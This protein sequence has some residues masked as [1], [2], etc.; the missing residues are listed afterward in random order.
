MGDVLRW[1][2]EARCRNGV[3]AGLAAGLL[4]AAGGAA[5][6]ADGVWTGDSGDW[7][8]PLIWV[9]GTVAGGVD[10]SASFPADLTADRTIFVDG[11]V[12]AGSLAFSDPDVFL[13]ATLT[14]APTTSG[15]LTLATT[16]DLPTVD[17]VDQSLIISSVLAGGQGLAK[18]GSGRLVLGNDAN[19]FSGTL[20]LREGSLQLAGDGSLGQVFEITVEN[21]AEI[22]SDSEQAVSIGASRYM[23]LAADL[24]FRGEDNADRQFSVAAPIVGTGGLALAGPTTDLTLAGP[25]SFEGGISV[26][27]GGSSGGSSND[28]TLVVGTGPTDLLATLGNGSNPV[29]LGGS[30]GGGIG[31][32]VLH[33]QRDDY[34]YS[35][36]ISGSGRVRVASG[37]RDYANGSTLEL[38]GTNTYTGITELQDTGLIVRDPANLS[39][40]TVVFNRAGM[41][42][43][44]GDLDPAS[45]DDFTRPVGTGFEDVR[46]GGGGGFGAMGGT[47]T[48]NLHGDGRQ[49]VWDQALYNWATLFLSHPDA[50]GTVELVNGLGLTGNNNSRRTITTSDGLA[51]IDAIISGV[52][53]EA[54]TAPGKVGLNLQGDGTLQLTGANTYGGGTEILGST[55]VVSNVQSGGPSNIGVGYFTVKQGGT[56][57]YTGTGAE[58]FDRGLWTDNGQ[59][60]FDIVEPTAVL[61]LDPFTGSRNKEMVKKGAGTM[62][63]ARAIGGGGSVRVEAGTLELSA[64][65]NSY[66]GTSRVVGGTLALSA[67]GVIPGSA[68]VQVD[69]LGTFDVTAKAAGYEVAAAQTLAGSGTVAGSIVL[70]G[71]GTVEPG[72]S[73][74]TLTVSQDATFAAGGNYNWQI[75]DALPGGAGLSTGWDLLSLG[76]GLTVTAT[77]DNPFNVNLWSLFATNP[78]EGGAAANF[79]STQAGAW[80]MVTTTSGITGF[81]A[82]AFLISTEAVNGTDGFVNDLAGGSFSVAVDG[83][84]LN[85]IFTPAGAV[86][87]IVID[88]P[89]GVQTQAEAG[90]P[91]I[92]TATSVTKIGAGTVVF[93]AANGYTG[94]TTVSAGTLELANGDGLASSPVTVSAGGTLA[95]AAGTT[96]RAPSVTLSGG[97]LAADSL[98]IAATTGVATLT[99]N[100]GGITGSPA[101]VVGAGGLV[102]LP[103]D[104]RVVVDVASLAVEETAGGGLIDLGS[105]GIGIAA[106]GI[107]AEQLRADIVAGRNGGSWDGTAGITSSAAAGSSGTRSVGYVVAGDGSAEVSFAAPGDADLSGQV[108]VIDLVGIDAAGKFGNG[109]AADWSQGDF[110]YDGVTNILDLVAIDTAGV[111]GTGSY[112]PA[113]PT[114]AAASVAAVPEPRL[115]A[116]LA[117]PLAAWLVVRRQRRRAAGSC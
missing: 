110:N 18:T 90:Y 5:S 63:F 107:T 47:R 28:T 104:A 98:T 21:P 51:D 77:V 39:P 88:V 8:N 99:I 4:L 71:G 42:L 116:A 45:P 16:A 102:D 2:A 64:S 113:P 87:D 23:S 53:A 91:S 97:S 94:P 93:D 103:D 34:I 82:D 59:A 70:G 112:F 108:N 14:L 109:E 111:F 92:A 13:P 3:V 57:R 22:Y 69:S 60:N 15:V 83:T 117:G 62:I 79:D 37:D 6:A 36:P 56:F 7:S 9:G 55:L 67:D 115:L 100:S 33:F 74:G 80:T 95:V 89:A 1:N 46:W 50:D 76:G 52:I 54:D 96:M 66:T 19:T 24:T 38:T 25:N 30:G 35:G 61:T 68:R 27:A 101:V 75:V 86:T 10:A 73:P 11:S 85:L 31:E 105:G 26:A 114:A 43:I 32:S 81:S 20:A 49:L 17:V 44:A 65:N 41:L 72:D 78:D 29:T 40:A 58:T 12:T 84:D 48:V 106:G